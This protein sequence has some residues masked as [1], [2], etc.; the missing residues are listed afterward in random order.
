MR[1]LRVKK[2]TFFQFRGAPIDNE[3]MKCVRLVT[4]VL[5]LLVPPSVVPMMEAEASAPSRAV[6]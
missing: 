2:K 3:A 1:V 6:P 5:D 4:L